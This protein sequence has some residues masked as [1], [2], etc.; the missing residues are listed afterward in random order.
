MGQLPSWPPLLLPSISSKAWGTAEPEAGWLRCPGEPSLTLPPASASSHCP[1][2]AFSPRVPGPVL[3]LLPLP[4]SPS[5]SPVSVLSR[6]TSVFPFPS[7]CLGQPALP[8]PTPALPCLAS[9]SAHFYD[10]FNAGS[11]HLLPSHSLSPMSLS[12][13]YCSPYNIPSYS[14]FFSS[15]PTRL[16]HAFSLSPILP[17]YFPFSFKA[18]TSIKGTNLSRYQKQ[19]NKQ[20]TTQSSK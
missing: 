18:G 3:P 1:P 2:R 15:L 5:I 9:L 8:S 19:T 7:L 14:S 10:C 4:L 11:L 16:S 20:K 13:L 17:M 12:S 6:L